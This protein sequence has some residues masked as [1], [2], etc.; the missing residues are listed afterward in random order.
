LLLGS[1]L[2]PYPLL[3]LA[4]QRHY[5]QYDASSDDFQA[6]VGRILTGGLDLSASMRAKALEE[7]KGA[8]DCEVAAQASQASNFVASHGS[9][10]YVRGA[11]ASSSSSREADGRGY[12]WVSSELRW[13]LVGRA[14]PGKTPTVHGVWPRVY[15]L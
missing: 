7:V 3:P 15:A 5:G 13:V 10:E 12:V 2:S 4:M 9:A 8:H 1:T 6:R 14:L 11:T